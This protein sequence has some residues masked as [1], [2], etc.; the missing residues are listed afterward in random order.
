MI[1]WLSRLGFCALCFLSIGLVSAGAQD[2]DEMQN[3]SIGSPTAENLEGRFAVGM[4]ALLKKGFLRD[5]EEKASVVAKGMINEYA[6]DLVKSS[7]YT[8]LAACGL[9]CDLAAIEVVDVSGAIF[10]QA[11]D[12]GAAEMLSFTPEKSAEMRV[13]ITVPGC[14]RALCSV[15][16][17][18][19]RREGDSPSTNFGSAQAN[20][21][22]PVRGGK[23]TKGGV[24]LKTPAA[25]ATKFAT[26]E[27][28]V[29]KDVVPV[30][31]SS[32]A[33]FGGQA[34]QPGM[35]KATE[36]DVAP[37]PSNKAE[38]HVLENYDMKGFDMQ[39][40][41]EASKDACV[42]ACKVASECVA[43]S[44]DK[45]N[46]YCFL[47]NSVGQL[48]LTARSITGVRG[49]PQLKFAD[50]AVGFEKFRNKRF[51][52]NSISRQQTG[53]LEECQGA[54]ASLKVCVAVT[55]LKKGGSCRLFDRASEYFTDA[56]ADSAAKIQ[57][58]D[59]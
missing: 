37:P 49:Y 2:D 5:G 47:K 42:E 31:E 13:R 59:Q 14:K 48:N 8:I 16:F 27:E 17:A 4:N 25:A 33:P 55:F 30:P 20:G 7:H 19:F 11:G 56:D 21:V 12:M 23:D 36:S 52:D 22:P 15:R 10:W 46:R 58:V 57:Y 41:R 9:G 24:K 1:M 35:R 54:C 43:F 53:S 45:W 34:P 38:F 26:D 32:A 51:P 50:V 40:I 29:T 44:Y 39:I 28:L 18:V 3:P 6:I